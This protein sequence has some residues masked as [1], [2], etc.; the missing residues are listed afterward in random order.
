[1]EGYVI[2]EGVI[3]GKDLA[4]VGPAAPD[5]VLLFVSPFCARIK[6]DSAICSVCKAKEKMSAGS[7]DMLKVGGMSCG[8]AE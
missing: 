6:D 8:K 4:V 2:E 7:W 3:V 1:M 5:S